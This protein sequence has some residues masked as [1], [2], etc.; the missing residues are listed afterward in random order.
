MTAILS[1]EY[2]I[3]SLTCILF[4]KTKTISKTPAKTPRAVARALAPTTGH[5]SS[6][7][8]VLVGKK[9]SGFTKQKTPAPLPRK[10]RK[11]PLVCGCVLFHYH[12]CE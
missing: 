7:A 4:Q 10:G 5:V 9:V 8:T 1:G 6:P 12:G 3:H 2:S 11:Q